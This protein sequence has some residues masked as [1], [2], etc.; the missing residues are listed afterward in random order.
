M[1]KTCE[2]WLSIV[3]NYNNYAQKTHEIYRILPYSVDFKAP[4][5]I[6]NQLSTTVLSECSFTWNKGPVN[7]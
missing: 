1:S 7:I 5:E 6:L 4:G 3:H 2:N